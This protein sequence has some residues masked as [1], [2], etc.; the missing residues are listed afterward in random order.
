LSDDTSNEK[1][2]SPVLPVTLPQNF[3]VI[4]FDSNVD[5][6]NENGTNWIT[7]VQR[8]VD[9]VT[10][11]TDTDDCVKFLTEVKNEKVLM[12]VSIT[13]DQSMVPVFEEF[14][15]VDSIYILGSDRTIYETWTDKIMK[16]KGVF[17]HIHDICDL[18]KL[19]IQASGKDL[20]ST[21]AILENDSDSIN[22][23]TSEYHQSL[24]H[25]Q[26]NSSMEHN[27]D[28][29]IMKTI[30]SHVS[31]AHMLENTVLI[32]LDLS[33]GLYEDVESKWFTEMRGIVNVVNRFTDVDDCVDFLTE[34]ENENV[35]MIVSE[36]CS[37]NV[38]THIEEFHQLKSIYIL[39]RGNA[40]DDGWINKFKK[41]KGVFNE[42]EDI[43][44]SLTH[45]IRQ[46][47]EA[48][49]PISI[50]RANDSTSISLNE[51]DQSFMHTQLIKE[52][53]LEIKYNNQSKQTFIDFCRRQ[54]SN[55][56]SMLR[57]INQFDQEYYAH[58][59]IWWY[60]K[61]PFIYSTLNRALRLQ[62]VNTIIMM[63]FFIKDLHC[64]IEH[65]YKE[66]SDKPSLQILYRGQGMLH[67][68]FERL[69]QSKGGL[70][71]FNNFL[72]TS[73][74]REISLFFA[75][76]NRMDLELTGVLFEIK[77]N[78]ELSSIP[79][80]LLD[81]I[82]HHQNE[83]EILFSMHSIFKIGEVNQ[84]DDR[85]WEV[86]LLSTTDNDQEMNALTECFRKEMTP[87][88]TIPWLQLG[89]LLIRMRQL[90][91]AEEIF[92]IFFDAFQV[93][94]I[95]QNSYVYAIV[96]YY[97]GVIKHQQGDFTHA[98]S[99]LQQTTQLNL[100]N[101][102]FYSAIHEYI[103]RLHASMG[104]YPAALET[105]K[106]LLER[107]EKVKNPDILSLSYF[108]VGETYLRFGKPWDALSYLKKGVEIKE[109]ECP[110]NYPDLAISYNLIGETLCM[111]A[112][113]SHAFFYYEKALKIQEK[114][115]PP[116]HSEFAHTLNNMG[117]F[118]REMKDYSNA[119]SCHKKTL[120]IRQNSLNPDH[121]EIAKTYNNIGMVFESMGN[122]SKALSC[123]QKALDIYEKL[124]NLNLPELAKTY[125]NISVIFR[126]MENYST[127]L[128]FLQKTLKIEQIS[129]PHDHSTIGTTYNTLGVTYREMGDYSSALLFLE[130]SRSIQEKHLHSNHPE[131]AATY[132]NIAS[133]YINMEDYSSALSFLEK[134]RI[135][136]ENHLRPDDSDRASVY[137]NLAVV[138]T[139]MKD[140][141]TALS[142]FEKSRI[143]QEKCVN[144]DRPNLAN[145]YAN[146]GA[147]YVIMGDNLTALSFLH[148][149]RKIQ[150][151]YF[152]PN[153]PA[154]LR[155]E[156]AITSLN[157]RMGNGSA[158]FS[159][160]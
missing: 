149:A 67:S 60:S 141:S 11:F 116:N 136:Q 124:A 39:K 52:I 54:Y 53:I 75:D 59:P 69:R 79:F 36:D 61:E 55:N 34:I 103:G 80:I 19:N 117:N 86:E 115:L 72:S 157:E 88:K 90:I 127:A 74:D 84:I 10:I 133:V 66:W 139:N 87:L 130:K 49:I 107:V 64:Q 118:Y 12:I 125:H 137:S 96:L 15:Q 92:K 41:V 120:Q 3:I 33:K 73:T 35:L 114:Y 37:Q 43:F 78:S 148:K 110:S 32:Y 122:Y 82:S 20:I 113:Y 156:Q 31:V 111:V 47:D 2:S 18:L 89:T 4:C 44:S 29:Q 99:L 1:N 101:D 143:I 159:F 97:M 23:P 16:V 158:K 140:Y 81:N 129:L 105:H 62:E 155:I 45:D 6:S 68:E 108:N 22:S 119:L 145:I 104:N 25:I 28:N 146:I 27:I 38:L 152:P 46:Y 135:I 123:Y 131:L 26:S 153:H 13:F 93:H 71:A 30:L 91:E 85:L 138:Y 70:L 126:Q 160:D 83:E 94:D 24:L 144:P 7:E 77:I 50:I 57:T 17:T 102:S 100:Q 98:L 112:D 9:F 106:K 142:F 8:I 58:S 128:E 109:K 65:L 134:A 42:I 21:S 150:E 147:L 154:R 63:G 56:D 151:K 5:Q 51:L 40:L 121:P 132:N 95:Y 76:S 48:L 14:A